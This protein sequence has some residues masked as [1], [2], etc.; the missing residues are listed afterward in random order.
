MV[1][2]FEHQKGEIFTQKKSFSKQIAPDHLF[3]ETFKVGI[4][5]GPQQRPTRSFISYLKSDQSLDLFL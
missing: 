1:R 5:I 4:Q 2:V 3:L